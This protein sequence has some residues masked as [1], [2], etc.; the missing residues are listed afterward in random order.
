MDITR[1]AI[2]PNTTFGLGVA[3]AVT[4][5]SCVSAPRSSSAPI[6]EETYRL[7]ARHCHSKEVIRMRPGERNVFD[8]NGLVDYRTGE[9]VGEA[10]VRRIH[11]VRRYL[12]I[13][14]E[15]VMIVMS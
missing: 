4:L 3:I 11:C 1:M 8:V 9:A 5:A 10:D 7:A 6:T 12:G 14:K 13:P 2:S 15:D